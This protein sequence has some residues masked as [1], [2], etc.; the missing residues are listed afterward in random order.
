[1]QC[2]P[3]T[4]AD[5]P[6]LLDLYTHLSPDD[7][8]TDLVLAR[9]NLIALG[10]YPGSGVL[11]GEVNGTLVASSTRIVIPNLSR[12][13]RPYALLENVVTHGDHRQMGYGTQMLHH[14]VEG[15]FA[16]GCYKVMLLT[17]TGKQAT[18]DFYAKAGFQQTKTGF[19]IRA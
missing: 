15:A 8:K 11:L 19:Q 1:M 10:A 9:A 18:L 12:R 16:Q 14:A 13:G 3:C 4:E 7:P 2:R 5:L 17:G 6:A